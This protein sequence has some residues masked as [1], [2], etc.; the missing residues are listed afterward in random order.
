MT[1]I[2]YG[3]DSYVEKE[4]KDTQSI[5]AELGKWPVTW[6]NV[7]GL[8]DI[9]VIRELGRM[10]GIHHLALEDVLNVRERPKVEDYDELLFV[11]AHMVQLGK[12]V[13]LLDA[14]Q[15]S[16]FL[17]NAF[18]LTFQ[19]R[20]GDCLDPVRLRIR[21]GRG[22][23]RQMGADYLASCLLDVV[24]DAYFPHLDMLS[25]QIEVL[26]D[27]VVSCPSSTTVARIHKTRSV[28]LNTRR[29]IAP[30]REVVNSLIRDSTP[31]ITE[32]TRP[33]LRDCLDHAIHLVDSID[34]HREVAGSL[35][36]IYLSSVSNRMNEVMKVLTVIATMFIPLTFLTGVYGMNFDY[37]VSHWNLPE[38]HLRYGY[39]LFWGIALIVAALELYVFWRKGWILSATLSPRV[40]R[41]RHSERAPGNRK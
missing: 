1:V 21:E 8:G 9:E 5:E 41:S 6:V 35:L 40:R 7:D 10:L 28:L 22:R 2:A 19:E 25:E 13:E 27:E 39:L 12:E 3:P 31:K 29:S 33:Y 16:M 30:L 11:V 38:L 18:V 15:L 24:I 36:D 17:G 34:L 14:E 23:V 20:E 32:G 4:V 37:S 26:E